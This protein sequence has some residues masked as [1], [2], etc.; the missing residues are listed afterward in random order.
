MRSK[1]WQF[2]DVAAC[3]RRLFTVVLSVTYGA[4]QLRH[5]PRRR[6]HHAPPGSSMARVYDL[7]LERTGLPIPEVEA[8]L[9]ASL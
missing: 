7:L 8:F 3:V 5:A 4:E 1:A 6:S 2:F 9:K